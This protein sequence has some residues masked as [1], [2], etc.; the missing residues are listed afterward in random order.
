MI[1]DYLKPV[2]VKHYKNPIKKSNAIN[3]KYIHQTTWSLLVSGDVDLLL[4]LEN[5]NE[6][7][8]VG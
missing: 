5:G 1:I 7:E 2:K 4:E 8:A 6:L 3:P